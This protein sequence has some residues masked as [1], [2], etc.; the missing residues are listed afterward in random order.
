MIKAF[1]NRI[2]RVPRHYRPR[3]SDEFKAQVV[4]QAGRRTRSICRLRSCAVDEGAYVGL[5]PSDGGVDTSLD[6]L[7]SEFSKPALD[8]IDP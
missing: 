7:S 3:Q 2:E 1:A 8:P 4:T 5:E 6:L